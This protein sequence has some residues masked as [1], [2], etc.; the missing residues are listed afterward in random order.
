[1]TDL[2][3]PFVPADLDLSDAPYPRELFIAIAMTD[4]GL[5][6]SEAERLVDTTLAELQR[7]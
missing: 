7:H 1:M 4:L 5:L 3:A 6:R 2:P